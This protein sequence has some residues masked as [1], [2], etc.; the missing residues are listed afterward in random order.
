MASYL[1]LLYARRAPTWSGIALTL[2]VL[3]PTFGLPLAFLMLARGSARAVA[4][5]V[6]LSLAVNLPL[7]AMLADRAGGAREFL[8]ALATGHQVSQESRNGNPATSPHRVD[9]TALISR[10]LGHPLSPASQLSLAAGM[11]V[12]AALT[13][14]RLSRLPG[15]RSEDLAIAIICLS[16][17]LFA[18][19]LGYDLLILAAPLAVVISRGLPQ[20][21]GPLGRWVCL[22]LYSVPAVNWIATDSVL[23]AWRPT[24]G[25]WL[26]VVS[27]NGMCVMALFLGYT[28]LAWRYRGDP[29]Y[30]GMTATAMS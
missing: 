2:S 26:L 5:G 29:T 27:A 24:P 12:L 28:W 11:L 20:P 1:S 10:G 23:S 3:K 15:K 16:I 13:L 30:A 4:I 22:G 6:V 19:H 7:Y 18:S 14:R 25:I 21:A 9:L 17:A 8:E